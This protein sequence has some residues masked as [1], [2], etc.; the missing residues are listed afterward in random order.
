LNGLM[1][2][3]TSFI[4]LSPPLSLRLGGRCLSSSSRVNPKAE[5]SRVPTLR[6]GR[7]VIGVRDSFTIQDDVALGLTQDSQHKN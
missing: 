3:I 6:E 7:Q 5:S 2:A 1:I 4:C